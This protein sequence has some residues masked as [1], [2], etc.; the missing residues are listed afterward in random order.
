MFWGVALCEGQQSSGHSAQ[1]VPSSVALGAAGLEADQETMG[2]EKGSFL[3]VP[4]GISFRGQAGASCVPAHG[5]GGL[6]AVRLT[7]GAVAV[8]AAVPHLVDLC[9]QL[10]W[11]MDWVIPPASQ[12]SLEGL[13]LQK[14]SLSPSTGTGSPPLMEARRL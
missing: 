7:N 10:F 2:G 3:P 13:L 6:G 14:G 12:T 8:P 1:R 5:Q 4:G 9:P 11:R